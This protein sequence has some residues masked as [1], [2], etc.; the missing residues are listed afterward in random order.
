MKIQC[1]V[2]Q[3]MT[4]KMIVSYLLGANLSHMVNPLAYKWTCYMLAMGGIKN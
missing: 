3:R 4:I 1:G 2:T